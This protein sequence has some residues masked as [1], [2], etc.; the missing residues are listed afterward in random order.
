MR[1][2][3]AAVLGIA[4]SLIVGVV[5]AF[6]A[7]AVFVNGVD[8]S[9]VRNQTFKKAT[10]RIDAK[11]D[12]HIDAPGYKVEVVDDPGGAPTAAQPAAPAVTPQASA[13]RF[14][15]VTK[16]S[17]DGRAQY[18]FVI[19]VNGIERKLIAAGSRQVILEITEWFT[20]GTNRVELFARKN[21]QGVRRSVAA[22]DSAEVIIGAGHVEA[23]VVKI[24]KIT[25]SLKVDASQLTDATK[26]ID[27]WIK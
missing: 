6:A 2:T 23:G 25:G 15:L 26:Q 27:V 14:Y 1:K 10:V 16:P 4:M 11:G 17:I 13:Q 20:L 21:V 19:R 12:I 22:S 3:S 18:D 8:I 7:R 9:F 24:D 5:P